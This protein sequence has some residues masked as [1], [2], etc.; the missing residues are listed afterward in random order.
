MS[1]KLLD[2]REVTK[3]FYKS[4]IFE[5]RSVKAVDKVSFDVLSE[6]EVVAL[7]GESGCGKT[8]ICRLILGL[9]TLTSG[10]I[11]YR[12]E[13]ITKWLKEN[14]KEY[15]KEV[16]IIFQDPYETFNPFYRADRLLEVSIKKF[17]LVKNQNEIK[18]MIFESL[19]A[20]GLRPKEIL[21]R[22]PHQLSGGERQRFMLARIYLIKPRL[23]VAD[24]PVSMLDASLRA[25]FLDHLKEFKRLGISSL[26][27]TH[28]LNT[29]NYIADRIII[30]YAGKLIE[31]GFTEDVINNPLH[32]Y[33][34][35]LIS[36][37]PVPDP[38][39]RWKEKI[40]IGKVKLSERINQSGCY[41]YNRCRYRMSKC[42]TNF[43]P[44]FD[45]DGRKVSCF[46]YE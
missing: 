39:N 41:Y 20:V 6:P 8:T 7:V 18:K 40:E 43:P 9:E 44:E 13:S 31:R 21:G 17:N 19:E 3:I 32:P 28:D 42:E 29:A 27:I 34:K 24:E 35:D 33:T 45:V 36:S 14:P 23:L 11:I 2:L 5:K 1:E 46:L 4:G 30:I 37:I 10:E 38:K 22:Y 12:G 26:Y 16:Q 25:M 15:R